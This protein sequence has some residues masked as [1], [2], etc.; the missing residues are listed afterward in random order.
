MQVINHLR[1]AVRKLPEKIQMDVR[2]AEKLIIHLKSDS[3]ECY[4]KNFDVVED[5]AIDMFT[6]ITE[7]LVSTKPNE[8][9]MNLVFN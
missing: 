9:F 2:K 4:N 5:A 1:R 7:C 3:F 8:T 6:F